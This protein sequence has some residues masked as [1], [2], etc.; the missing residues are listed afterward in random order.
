MA[1]RIQDS[2]I[3]GEIDNRTKGIVRGRLWLH[4]IVEPIVLELTGNAHADLAPWDTSMPPRPR[5]RKSLPRTSCP[6][7]RWTMPAGS[8][9]K[10][11]KGSWS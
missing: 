5:W 2:V 4:G 1:W 6:S 10:S 8:C 7:W 3:R 11:V 9:S